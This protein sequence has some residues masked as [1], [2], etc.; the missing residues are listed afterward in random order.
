MKRTEFLRFVGGQTI[1][2][3]LPAGVR[4][5]Q[6][7]H[8]LAFVHSGLPVDKL[9]EASGPFW[10]RQVFKALRELGDVE[11]R[12]LI[13]ERFSAEGQAERFASLAAEVVSR[14]PDAILVNLDSLA[15]VFAAATSR[16]PLIVITG[17]PIASGLVTNLAH[18]GGNMTGVSINAGIEIYGKRMQ[19]VKEAMP[20][21]SKVAA[22]LVRTWTGSN[23]SSAYRDAAQQSGIE[24]T[25]E[26]L[27]DVDRSSLERAFDDMA[28]QHFD[29][30]IVDESGSFV[31]QQALIVELAAKHRMP[32][33]YPYREYV[34]LGG[35]MAYAPDLGELARRL[36]SDVH[37]V[38]NGVSPGDIPFYQPSKFQL[39]VN[40]KT[41]AA[42]G[43]ELPPSLL[44]RS[45]EVIE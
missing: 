4:A 13:V 24:L 45:D 3:L 8:R 23:G 7:P 12:N 33:I 34:E 40:A 18:P 42:L 14:K 15:K 25:E 32:V 39:I 9:T 31:A 26:L 41:A 35:L 11:D 38:F 5:Q 22:L 2:M 1:A 6:G 27:P 36:A 21:A 28:N 19:I 16:I 30:A 29:A 37:Q 44:G 10:V 17:D 43:L 20:K